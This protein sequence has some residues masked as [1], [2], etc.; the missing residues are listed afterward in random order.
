[1]P[2][3]LNHSDDKGFS[4]IVTMLL[5]PCSLSN[6]LISRKDVGIPQPA[7]LPSITQLNYRRE[8]YLEN[9][10]LFLSKSSKQGLN[11]KFLLM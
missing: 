9:L 2:L 10:A 3:L 5:I 6:H 8:E 7:S 4:F 11:S 1:M